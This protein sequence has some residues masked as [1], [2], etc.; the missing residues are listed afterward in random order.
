MKLCDNRFP[1]AN[2]HGLRA[3]GHRGM[4]V[5]PL[6]EFDSLVWFW[7][8]WIFCGGVSGRKIGCL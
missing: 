7:K 1:N 2:G 3:C 5:R 4:C 8:G 6:L